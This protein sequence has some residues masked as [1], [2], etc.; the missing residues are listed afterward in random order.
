MVK[1]KNKDKIVKIATEKQHITKII[2][3][4]LLAPDF[5]SE[6]VQAIRH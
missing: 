5:K 4:I 6:K 1:V 2:T 3:M